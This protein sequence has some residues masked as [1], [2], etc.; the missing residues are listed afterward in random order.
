[1][2]AV[3]EAIDSMNLP[4]YK[5]T[6]QS[7][8]RYIEGVMT[9]ARNF[10]VLRASEFLNFSYQRLQYL[11]SEARFKDEDVEIER[12]Q[13]AVSQSEQPEREYNFVIIDDTQSKKFILFAPTLHQSVMLATLGK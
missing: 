10:S 3:L 6:K 11:V 8:K 2:E 13:W 7:M 12:L 5:G 4:I 9:E 1:M